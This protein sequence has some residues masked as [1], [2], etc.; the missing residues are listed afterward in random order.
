M[1]RTPLALLALLLAIPSIHAQTVQHGLR[2]PDGFEVVEYA[3]SKLAND[4]FHMTIDPKG[5]VVVSGAGYIR[6]LVDEK[7]EGKATKA[8][9]VAAPREGAQGMLWEGDTLYYSSDGGLRRIQIVDDKAVGP[10]ELIRK[11]R[12]GNEHAIHAI[13]RGPDGWLYLLTGDHAGIDKSFATLPTSPIK[14]PIG[15]CVLR[16]T[17][18][19]KNSEIVTDGYRNPYDMDFNLD[20]ELFTYDSD[21]ERCVSLPWYEPTR[22]YHVIP[23]GHYGWLATQRGAFWRLPDYAPDV[24]PPILLLGRGSPTGVACYRHVQFPARYRGGFFLADWTFGRIYFVPM[25]R[26]GASYECQKE[27]FL[28]AVG[29]EGFAP[30]ALAV[31]PT[32]GDLFVCIGGRGTRGAVYRIRHKGGA[33]N[34]DR[35]ALAKMALPKRSL[36]WSDASFGGDETKVLNWLVSVR[37]HKKHELVGRG[38]MVPACDSDDRHVRRA[39]AD[40]LASLDVAARDD[41]AKTP[42]GSGHV[43]VTIALGTV[44]ADPTAAL[45][46]AAG[47]LRRVDSAPVESRRDAVRVIQ[48][49]I[50][51]IVSPAAR[52]LIWEGY[53]PRQAELNKD[54]V[55]MALKVMHE[56]FPSGDAD[57]DREISRTF[58]MLEDDDAGTLG[59]VA[60]KLTAT[61]PPIEDFHYLTVLARLKAPRTDAITRATASALLSLD[62]KLDRDKAQR[63]T[64]WPLRMTELLGELAKKDPNLRVA[65]LASPDF[66]RPAHALLTQLTGFDKKK[67]AEIFLAKASKDPN[68]PWNGDIV[69]LLGNLPAEQALP[70]L[71]KL[72]GQ[73]GLE[74]AMLPVLAQFAEPADRDK[75]LFGLTSP[76][77]ATVQVSLDAL[78]KLPDKL[79]DENHVLGVILALRRL[80]DTKEEKELTGRLGKYLERLTGQK[81]AAD[82]K[83]WADWFAGKYPKLAARLSGPDGVDVQAWDKRL[84]KVD[85]SAGDAERG[86]LVFTKANCASCHSGERALGPDLRGVAGRF[87]R[88]DVLTAIIQPSKDISPRYRTTLI[89]TAEGK[90]YQGL[91]IYEA[92]DSLIL[93]TGPS[94]TIRLVNKQIASRRYTDT[95]LMPAGLLDMLKDEEIADLYAYLKS[96]G[97]A[98]VDKK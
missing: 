76:Q 61:S 30:T 78:E 52:G 86:K 96:Q 90:V 55:A 22:F 97:N 18:D 28:E 49:A 56:T 24:V 79:S 14:E 44:S 39:A 58:A 12:T 77:M 88:D 37:R 93:Q 51:D 34:I 57:I 81:H 38:N 4:I 60:V 70:V 29:E 53:T 19:L 41:I 25:K 7:N 21:N 17:P 13:R 11:T 95:S 82:K 6:V 45:G 71:R 91:I 1:K 5:R 16:F 46:R 33:K 74:E 69:R 15:G 50:G 92:V 3:D 87:S 48:L 26:S 47:V 31:H 42:C 84:A 73:A 67:G 40:L 66:G 54:R 8:I 94:A 23:G 43:Q 59:K 10:S 98:A 83:A 89:E 9:D 32:T 64:Y 35:V 72:W 75:F 27:V 20:G 80:G 68:Y 62:A 36:E 63:D 65:L 2:V 85:W